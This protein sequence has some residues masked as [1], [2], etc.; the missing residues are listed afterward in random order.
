MMTLTSSCKKDIEGC[1]DAEAENY[2]PDANVDS[3]ICVFARDKFLGTFVGD[4]TC[5]A[6]LPNAEAFTITFSEGLTNN[7]EVEV[8]FQNTAT[9]IPV[10][11]GRVDGDK[12]IID[13]TSTSVALDPNLPN[14]KTDLT[15]S[16]EA[17]LSPNGIDLSGELRVL[18]NIFGQTLTCEINASKQ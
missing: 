8:S 2:N 6:P 4:L 11:I 16:G 18:I 13:P 7:A 1:L 5:Q 10:L 9:P 3:G 15:F 17:T 12:I 14:L